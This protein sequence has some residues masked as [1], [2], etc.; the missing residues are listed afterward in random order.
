V[1]TLFSQAMQQAFLLPTLV[2]AVGL[3]AVLAYERPRHEGYRSRPARPAEQ[4]AS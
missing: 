1:A 2:Y 4:P 3:L